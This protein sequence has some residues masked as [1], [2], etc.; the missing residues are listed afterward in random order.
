MTE[1]I[2]PIVVAPLSEEDGGGFVA[3]APDLYG[4][5]SDGATEAE[6][7]AN[8]KSAIEEWC[9]EALRMGRPIPEPFSAQKEAIEERNELAE[10]VREQE[11]VIE[12]QE[13]A[14]SN[15]EARFAELRE[16]T[17]R[18]LMQYDEERERGFYSESTHVTLR[19]GRFLAK[20]AH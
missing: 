1:R 17:R 9:D 7:I 12:A 16:R 19:S 11:G 3:F 14:I 6:A 18:V 13:E 5:L 20:T 4:C 10:L 8:A 15:L 2:Y